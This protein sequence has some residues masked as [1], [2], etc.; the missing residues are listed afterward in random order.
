MNDGSKDGTK[1]A[2]ERYQAANPALGIKFYG[3]D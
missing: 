3:P 1:A 2:I